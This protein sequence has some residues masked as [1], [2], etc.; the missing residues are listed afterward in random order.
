M[1][2][3]KVVVLK[4]KNVLFALFS[5]VTAFLIVFMVDFVGG[6]LKYIPVTSTDGRYQFDS[7]IYYSTP[8][9]SSIRLNSA[10]YTVGDLIN[11][12]ENK[13]TE[14]K[15][16]CTFE[17]LKDDYII[18]IVIAFIMIVIRFIFIKVSLKLV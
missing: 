4:R 17:S 13:V 15:L 3:K 16:Y 12:R 18:I 9:G 8:F 6:T 11:A 5:F 14:V 10:Q 7:S 2:S 1:E